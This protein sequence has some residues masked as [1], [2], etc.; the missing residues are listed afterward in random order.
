MH[1]PRAFP[2]EQV[3]RD[4]PVRLP[5]LEC[6]SCL[7]F[8]RAFPAE[9]DL[10]RSNESAKSRMHLVSHISPVQRSVLH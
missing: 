3:T 5:N 10:R 8:S 9:Q 6:T 7:T 1:D 4:G 2:A